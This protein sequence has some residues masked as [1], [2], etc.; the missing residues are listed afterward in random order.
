MDQGSKGISH[1]N[2]E[3]NQESLEII[4]DTFSYMAENYDAAGVIDHAAWIIEKQ[5]LEN[6]AAML[7][8][9]ADSGQDPVDISMGYDEWNT[10]SRLV[11]YAGY[12]APK[13]EDRAL[14][15]D[16]FETYS[17]WE[18]EGSVPTGPT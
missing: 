7:K 18:D 8:P 9:Y 4:I 15:E 13:Q 16:L 12:A 11:D 3:L 5:E 10:Y 1:I 2:V 14:L 6:T 17:D